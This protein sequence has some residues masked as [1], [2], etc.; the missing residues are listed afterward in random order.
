MANTVGTSGT[1]TKVFVPPPNVQL[2]G[3]ALIPAKIK[4]VYGYT[5]FMELGLCFPIRN[6]LKLSIA[7][8]MDA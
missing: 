3:A 8:R 2:S 7:L 4:D 1:S 5:A 6:K